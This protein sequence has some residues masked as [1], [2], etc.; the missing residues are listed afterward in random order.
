MQLLERVIYNNNN[1]NF[2][3]ANTQNLFKT[4]QFTCR[5]NAKILL[6]TEKL[7]PVS[8]TCHVLGHT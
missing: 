3:G 4:N 8:S 5:Y 7:L 1:F 6:S 2:E